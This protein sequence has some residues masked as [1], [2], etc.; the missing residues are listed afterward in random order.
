MVVYRRWHDFP[1]AIYT[2]A[3]Q[4]GFQDWSWAAIH[5]FNST[6][7]VR[8]GTKSIKATYGAVVMKA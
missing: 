4:N 8:Q 6:A 5:D 7:N 2:D 1:F 3:L